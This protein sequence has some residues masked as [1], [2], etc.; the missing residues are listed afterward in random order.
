VPL[1]REEDGVIVPELPDDRFPYTQDGRLPFER[2]WEYFVQRRDAAEEAQQ[3]AADALLAAQEMRDLYLDAMSCGHRMALR[4]GNCC[5]S[6]VIVDVYDALAVM[7][8]DD[9]RRIYINLATPC[10]PLALVRVERSRSGGVEPW[11][12]FGDMKMLLQGLQ[13]FPDKPLVEVWW[14]AALHREQGW[15]QTVGRDHVSIVQGTSGATLVHL[16]LEHIFL[17]VTR[18]PDSALLL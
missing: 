17:V 3:D 1:L 5:F 7:D 10:P 12:R 6:G 2:E 15:V 8:D 16:P 9:G 4:G 13:L 18:V 11:I 14:S